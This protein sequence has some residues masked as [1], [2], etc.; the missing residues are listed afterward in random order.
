MAT[1]KTVAKKTT[2]VT[3]STTT[4]STAKKKTVAKKNAVTSKKSTPK[5][6]ATG[7]KN[8]K[9]GITREQRHLLISETAYFLS[10]RR[11]GSGEGGS[12][13]DWL[14]AEESV[15]EKYSVDVL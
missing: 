1:K 7:L 4:K 5:K 13:D 11:N 2:P 8:K 3:K 10:L 14:L 12:V 9:P 15:D 6:A